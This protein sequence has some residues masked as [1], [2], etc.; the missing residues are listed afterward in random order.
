MKI[1]CRNLACPE[2]VLQTKKALDNLQDNDI[3]EVIINSD[4]S[5]QNIQ[6]FATKGG[7]QLTC[8]DEANGESCITIIK[9]YGCD[10]VEE[11]DEKFLN[12]V[13][14]LKSDTIGDGELGGKLVVGFLRSIAE[15]PQ[16]PK[17][18]ICVNAAV[19]LT[20]APQ[21]SDVMTALKVLEQKGVEIFSCGVCLEYFGLSDQLKVGVVG[22]AYGTVEMLVNSVGTISL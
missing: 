12:K 14:F 4:S 2:P 11:Q 17:T 3:L 9:G 15:L 22:N 13:I 1:D 8:K 6:R 18:L 20:T 5:K 19:K 16:L 21:D 10:I 7:F